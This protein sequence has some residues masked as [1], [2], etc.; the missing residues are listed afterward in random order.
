MRPGERFALDGIVRDGRSDV[1][2]APIT[3]ESLP[4][5][6][7]PGDEVFAGTINGHGA[8]AVTVT[9]RRDDTT[10][11]RIVHLV[12]QA[13]ARTRAR[14]AVHRSLRRVVHAGDRRPRRRRGVSF[15]SSPA[16]HP[17]DVGVSR[18]GPAGR[19][20]PVRARHLDAGV[21][22]L[23]AGGRGAARRA[24]QGRR[25]TSSGWPAISRRGL[26]QDRHADA[27]RRSAR[28]GIRSA[29]P[30]HQRV[31]PAGRGGVGRVSSPSIRLPRPSCSEARTRALVF[32]RAT[33]VRALPGLGV[34]GR[35]DGVDRSLCRAALLPGHARSDETLAG[36]PNRLIAA[37]LSPVIVTRDGRAIGVWWAWPTASAIAGTGHGGRPPPAR[38]RPRGDAHRRQRSQRAGGRRSRGRRRSPRRT[39]AR[40]QGRRPCG[41]LRG[42]RAASRWSATASTTRRRWPPPT[43][44][45]RWARWAA[46]RRIET[47]DIALMT[48]D[49][50]KMPYALRLSRATHAQRP[51]Q[52]GD[53]ARIEGWRSW[54]RRR[55][56]WPRSGWRCWPTPARRSSCSPTRCGCAA[57]PEPFESLVRVSIS[58]ASTG[59]AASGEEADRWLLN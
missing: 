55:R 28:R 4:V 39:A 23:R 52:R 12:E 34:E 51:R 13:Q 22:R 35:V 44:A 49:L 25:L 41:A 40:R 26:R 42:D 20:L 57:S 58:P 3:G 2:Q 59:R 50:S 21:D 30:R 16:V 36:R 38:H 10:L 17:G 56:A 11:A 45:S 6:K 29:S 46:T 54:P 47:A 27:R 31:R 15:P 7:A 8:L 24:H 37:G 1:N 14:P 5:E 43:S 18:A 33:D 32:P 19:R 53:R 48:D 9:R